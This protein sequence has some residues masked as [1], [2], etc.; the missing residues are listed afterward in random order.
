MVISGERNTIYSRF[1]SVLPGISGSGAPS[2]HDVTSEALVQIQVRYEI[3]WAL[4]F[5][6]SR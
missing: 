3:G 5:A 4:S 1:F 6:C 2:S